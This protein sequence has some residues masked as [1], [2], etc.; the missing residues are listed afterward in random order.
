[1]LVS[2]LKAS[3]KNLEFKLHP[4]MQQEAITQLMELEK[5]ENNGRRRTIAQKDAKKVNKSSI[6]PNEN[7]G[8]SKNDSSGRP[9]NRNDIE[10]DD[11]KACQ[12]T[13]F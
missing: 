8:R 11:R 5:E 10:V 2:R 13:I 4:W 7:D 3:Q 12:C 9:L 6:K 1:M